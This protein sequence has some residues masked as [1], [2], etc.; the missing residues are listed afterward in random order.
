MKRRAI[1]AMALAGL[2]AF[3]VRIRGGKS[4]SPQRGGWRELSGPDLH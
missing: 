4:A 3:A 1:L 2:A